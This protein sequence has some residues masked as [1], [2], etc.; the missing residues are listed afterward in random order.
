MSGPLAEVMRLRFERV[1]AHIDARRVAADG[2]AEDL[3]LHERR[4]AAKHLRLPSIELRAEAG[5]LRDDC[6]ERVVCSKRL[7]VEQEPRQRLRVRHIVPAA[8]AASVQE[9]EHRR[10]VAH[11]CAARA[12]ARVWDEEFEQ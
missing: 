3:L 6:D 9:N 11:G 10:L 8:L 4:D 2:V 5:A 7:V 1:H 12:G